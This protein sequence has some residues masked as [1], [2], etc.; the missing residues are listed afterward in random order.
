VKAALLALLS[1]CTNVPFV[2]SV[3]GERAIGRQ[4]IE[5]WSA[6]GFTYTEGAGD[7]AID[8]R[9]EIF[10]SDDCSCRVRGAVHDGRITID[11]R[12]EGDELLHT[13]RHEFG[14]VLLDA[15]HLG[16]YLEP[17]WGNDG[18]M[19]ASPDEMKPPVLEPTSD[20]FALACHTIGVCI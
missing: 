20:D 4:A 15:M 13:A 2:V 6:L 17:A 8:V 7:I 9:R 1:A 10:V 5:G 3:T 16:S 18:I 12:L 11:P 14:H 19:R